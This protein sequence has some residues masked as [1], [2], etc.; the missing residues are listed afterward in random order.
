MKLLATG[1]NGTVGGY[2]LR[3]FDGWQIDPHS[4]ASL[5][6]TDPAACVETITRG[7]PD[8]VLHLAA[9]TDVDLCETDPDL[10]YRVNTQG[11]A[12][13]S[14]ACRQVGA[15]LVYVSTGA[16]F[17]RPEWRRFTEQDIPQ[18]VSVYARTKL[19]GETYADLTVRAG[20]MFGG[21]NKFVEK[22]LGQTG[23]QEIRAVTDRLGSPTYALDLLT[24]TRQLVELGM[25]GVVH[26]ANEGSATRYGVA[27]EIVRLTGSQARVSAAVADDFVAA[28]ARPLSEAIRSDRLPVLGIRMRDWQDALADYLG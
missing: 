28:A 3:A 20:W 6:V 11:T 19:D 25:R 26:C 10:A 16:V 2:L 23:E 9:V 8:V 15:R 12:N 5:D 1:S 24:T 7:K 17:G 21:G 13:L 22:I 27:Q 4:H 18:P 14:A